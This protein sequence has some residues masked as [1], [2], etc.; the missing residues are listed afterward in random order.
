MI[1]FVAFCM[2]LGKQL[3]LDKVFLTHSLLSRNRRQA[4]EDNYCYGLIARAHC[5]MGYVQNYV[6]AIRKCGADANTVNAIELSCR[7]SERGLYCIEAMAYVAGNCTGS[8]CTAGC[9]NSLRLAGCC[10]IG[11]ASSQIKYLTTCN[12]QIPSPWKTLTPTDS[13]HPARSFVHLN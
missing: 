8:T 10:V 13:Q 1:L 5:S 11:G 6:N 4:A 7:K 3:L 9:S 2:F 12:I